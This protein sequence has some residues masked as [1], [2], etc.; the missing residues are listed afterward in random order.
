MHV[1]DR[2]GFLK[3]AIAASPLVA[4]P[5]LPSC[6]QQ[7]DSPASGMSTGHRA[8]GLS[9][10]I[11][12]IA[13]PNDSGLTRAWFGVNYGAINEEQPGL[14]H[15]VEHL[16]MYGGAGPFDHVAKRELW[17]GL[18]EW[19]G[20]S[21]LEWVYLF[22]EMHPDQLEIFLE[23]ASQ[24][25][26]DPRF[27]DEVLRQQ[28]KIVIEEIV[29]DTSHP[30][31]ADQRRF[32]RALYGDDHPLA[33][34]ITGRKEVIENL[35]RSDLSGFADRGF[36]T[37]LMY[38]LLVGEFPDDVDRV[39]DDHLGRRPADYG[40]AKQ[41]P[42]VDML[43]ENEVI[44]ADA[45][46][47]NRGNVTIDIE[48]NTDV[49]ATHQDSF[50]MQAMNFLFG[51]S[52]GSRL[53]REVRRKRG[54]VYGI[55]SIYSP[56]YFNGGISISTS[57]GSDADRVVDAIFAV[58]RSMKEVPVAA[59]EIEL[60]ARHH[61]FWWRKRRLSN[62]GRM[63]ALWGWGSGSFALRYQLDAIRRLTP[64]DIL[65]VAR[66]HMPDQ[67]RAYVLMKRSGT[68][69]SEDAHAASRLLRQRA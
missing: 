69:S 56:T 12:V 7:G 53:M 4:L 15:L 29:E 66:A 63:N 50:A 11:S 43:T 31:H 42:A 38:L 17:N 6:V 3:H 51:Y 52:Y 61:E 49:I 19:N 27:E 48:W 67:D 36:K 44:D 10:G 47:L 9:N 46:D 32:R 54:L 25:I 65:R 20:G 60:F 22:A 55:R 41:I 18:P 24:S 26:F 68:S 58:V 62:E 59:E 30:R 45:P 2:R 28:A 13:E 37:N 5:F 1:I 57:T 33:R 64:E 34:D 14:A 39:I 40:T 16:L 35:R 21:N 8:G 23:I